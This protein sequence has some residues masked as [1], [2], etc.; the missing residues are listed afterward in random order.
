MTYREC[1]EKRVTIHVDFYLQDHKINAFVLSMAICP[2]SQHLI[3]GLSVL[4]IIAK[5]FIVIYLLQHVFKQEQ[6]EYMREGIDW[7]EIKFVDNQPLLDL[8][9]GKPI[10]LLSLLDEESQFPKV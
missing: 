3:L 2:T 9:L 8:F 5:C 10:G 7:K 6:E 4:F 1:N